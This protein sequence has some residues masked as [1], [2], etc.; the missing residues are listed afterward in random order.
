MIKVFSGAD[1][2]P[3]QSVF[4][5]TE[6]MFIDNQ[7]KHQVHISLSLILRN[8]I[9]PLLQEEL[10]KQ[11]LEYG[12]L[13]VKLWFTGDSK[14]AEVGGSCGSSGGQEPNRAPPD[15]TFQVNND[16]I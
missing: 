2:D 15:T 12:P 3:T 14:E 8:Y 5:Q 4:R 13:G 16:N 11:S 1:T 10:L 6:Q 7:K 9:D